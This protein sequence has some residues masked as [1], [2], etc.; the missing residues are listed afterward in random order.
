[1]KINRRS[2]LGGGALFAASTMTQGCRSLFTGS[3]SDYDDSLT[4]FLS[5]MHIGSSPNSPKHQP[6]KF[7]AIVVEILRMDPLPRRAIV[8]GDISYKAGLKGDYVNAY[9]FFRQLTD[10]GI[11]VTLGMGNH[12]RRPT[13][14]EVWPEYEKSSPVPGRIVSVVPLPHADLVMLDSLKTIGGGQDEKSGFG[15]GELGEAQEEWLVDWMS[16]A[17][18]PFFLASHHP[19]FEP[20][21]HGI[22]V[23]RKRID[24]LMYRYP[25]A[26]GY[27]HGH[28][29][30]WRSDLSTVHWWPDGEL[31]IMGLPSAGYWGDIGYVLFRTF[32]T[33]ARATLHQSEHFFPRSNGSVLNDPSSHPLVWRE[34]TRVL[35]G[36]TCLFTFPRAWP[37]SEKK[38]DFSL[39]KY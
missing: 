30:A 22:F 15:E 16:K 38:R 1:M 33:G 13:F 2:F 11:Q 36:Q 28:N 37:W 12:D 26:A 27:I 32:P 5:D 25:L 20:P 3:A 29:H 23:K 6:L 35:N 34:R 10:A 19:E 24:K 39:E 7:G 31:P 17:K 21:S 14:L 9:P 18:R 8:F 4:V